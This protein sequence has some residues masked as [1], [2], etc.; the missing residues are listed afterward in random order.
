MTP[1]VPGIPL[2]ARIRTSVLSGTARLLHG[3]GLDAA[4]GRRYGGSGVVLMFHEFVLDSAQTLGQGCRIDDFEAILAGL[5]RQGRAFV[6]L[7]EAQ[8]RLEAGDTRPFAALTFDDGYRSNMELALPVMERH[9][10]PAT[11]FVPT[12]MLNRSINAWWLGLRELALHHD[13][14]A[15]EPMGQIIE[16]R[17]RAEKAAALEHMTAWVWADFA[18][19]A[20]LPDVFAAHGL[21]MP[22]LVERLAMTPDEVKA[23]DR[24]PLV[25]IGAHTTTHRAL[26]LLSEPDAEADIAANK[27]HLEALLSREVR[28]FAYPYGAPSISGTR[29]AEILRRLGFHGAVTTEPG[30]LFPQH[31]QARWLWPR[32]NGEFAAHAVPQALSGAHGVFRALRSG[33]GEPAVN[34]RPTSGPSS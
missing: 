28:W 17:T 30:C 7:D 25:E 16:S 24:H 26:A 32:Q 18:R 31:A 15:I 11:I 9:G 33:W 14:L 6:T 23:I 29:E 21:N 13:R 8:R 10:A 19:A 2:R 20:L 12:D 34:T 4:V 27:T 3:L 22:G 5:Q 1:V